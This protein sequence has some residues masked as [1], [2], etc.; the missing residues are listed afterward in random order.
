MQDLCRNKS[1][2][3]AFGFRLDLS[4]PKMKTAGTVKL[5]L[6]SLRLRNGQGWSE[7][8]MHEWRTV[9]PSSLTFHIII[10]IDFHISYFTASSFEILCE[11]LHCM[12]CSDFSLRPRENKYLKI[13]MSIPASLIW[14]FI[15]FSTLAKV[16]SH[17][18]EE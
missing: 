12:I 1:A 15:L 13:R 9:F 18:S 16:S 17:F 2:F 6:R 4:D 11:V 10:P 5:V 3:L 7:D 8:E 14:W